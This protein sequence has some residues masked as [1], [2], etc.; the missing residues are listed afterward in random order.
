MG[1]DVFCERNEDVPPADKDPLLLGREREA[2]GIV[3]KL[4]WCLANESC[5]GNYHSAI[6]IDI[7]LMEG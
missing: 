7:S 6:H 3:S 1:P 4:T 5:E 2:G